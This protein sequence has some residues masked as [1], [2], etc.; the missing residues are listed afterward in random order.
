MAPAPARTAVAVIEEE[1]PVS[2]E[3]TDSVLR[4]LR[5]AM[6]GRPLDELSTGIGASSHETMR[7]CSALLAAGHI[8]RRGHKYFVA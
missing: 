7:A 1:A 8:V 2:A 3:L 4:E 6:R 5:A